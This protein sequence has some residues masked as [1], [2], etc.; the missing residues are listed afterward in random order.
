MTVSR[1]RAEQTKPNSSAHVIKY[2]TITARHVKE[3]C[4]VG[5]VSLRKTLPTVDRE[6]TSS[7]HIA[8]ERQATRTIIS[9]LV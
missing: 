3:I 4:P 8:I 1:A 2:G 5:L 7:V 9:G 6:T